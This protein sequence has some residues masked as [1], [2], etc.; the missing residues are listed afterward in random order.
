MYNF[1]QKDLEDK[2]DAIGILVNSE[3][4][5]HIEAILLPIFQVDLILLPMFGHKV[6]LSITLTGK[7]DN[8]PE[9]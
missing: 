2:I 9:L 7:C 4:T 6:G 5:V 3:V 8:Q 1:R